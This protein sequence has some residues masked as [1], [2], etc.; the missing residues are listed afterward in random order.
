MGKRLAKEKPE[1]RE[2]GVSDVCIS[3]TRLRTLMLKAAMHQ[4]LL[5]VSKD[6]HLYVIRKYGAVLCKQRTFSA[7]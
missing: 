4:P 6:V 2:G 1:E 3:M 5:R 7:S